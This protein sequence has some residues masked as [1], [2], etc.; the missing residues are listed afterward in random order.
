M[1]NWS[2]P[3]DLAFLGRVMD[4]LKA[5]KVLEPTLFG[6]SAPLDLRGLT[7]PTVTQC[8]VFDLPTVSASRVA[9]HLEFD[10]NSLRDV[11][12]SKA[13]LD[14]SV[15]KNCSFERVCFDGA[16]LNQVRFLGC[17]FVDCSFRS[18]DLRNSSFSVGRN[19]IE[20]EITSTIFER[21]DFRGASCSNPILR[22][23]SILNCKFNGFVFDGALCEQVYF[24]GRYKE[25]TF[26]GIPS[27]TERN[28]LRIDLSNASLM[29]LNANFG[30]D[31]SDVV[32]P[33][34]GSCLIIKDRLRA[35]ESLF[36][37]LPQEAGQAGTLVANVLNALFSDR[38]ISPLALT[39]DT[40][41]ISKDM[42][43]DFAETA[44]ANVVSSVFNS[45]RTIC[46]GDGFLVR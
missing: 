19:G 4:V 10:E 23:V 13:R 6:A 14:F 43:A 11:D 26:R 21:S 2:T 1:R 17:R 41:L 44:D 40:F 38:A 31:L 15:W 34:D 29:W 22:S 39:Q 46:H 12:F 16:K 20:T 30:V 37:R 27:D 33:V 35:V 9:G 42:I 8:K 36:S 28:R 25:L 7:F 24:T 5:G 45:I 3:D 18:V 32:L